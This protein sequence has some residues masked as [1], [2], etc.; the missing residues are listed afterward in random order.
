MEEFNIKEQTF[1]LPKLSQSELWGL[2]KK[3]TLFISPSSHD[4]TPN[5][6]LEAMACGSV[7]ILG[8]I[9]SL[10][11]WIEDG[12]NGFL[13]DPH[14][15]QALTKAILDALRKPE[16]LERAAQMNRDIIKKRAVEEVTLPRIDSFYASFIK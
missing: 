14:D 2:F 10:R 7:P 16:F 3:S 13:V 12:Q 11:E 9:E 1:L 6:L 5:T 4:G 8:D 15:P